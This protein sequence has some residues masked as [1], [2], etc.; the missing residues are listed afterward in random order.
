[1]V[2]CYNNKDCN[3]GEVGDGMYLKRI[4][5]QGF[6]SFADKTVIEVHHLKNCPASVCKCRI[7]VPAESVI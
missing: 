1:M 3:I 6:K 2:V 4:E 5:L 7:K